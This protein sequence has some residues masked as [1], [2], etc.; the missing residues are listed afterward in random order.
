MDTMP[1]LTYSRWETNG[2]GGQLH[3][4][5]IPVQCD[6]VVGMVLQVENNWS[7]L[8]LMGHA[9]LMVAALLGWSVDKIRVASICLDY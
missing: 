8:S 7:L 4:Q 9:M 6:K 1:A 3:Q 5:K 2:I